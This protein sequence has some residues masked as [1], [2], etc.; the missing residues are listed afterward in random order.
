MKFYSL[1]KILEKKCQYNLVI[2]ERSNGKSYAAYEE[3][4][5]N[6]AESGDQGAIIRRYREDFKGKRGQSFFSPHVENGLVQ[7]YTGDEWTG[8]YYYSSQ[9][10][11]CRRDE[12]DPNK[13]I[14]S[15]E[16]FCYAFSLTDMEHDK[17]TSYPKVTT[18]VFD[19]FITR[20]GYLNDEFVLFMNV[21]STIIRYRNNVTIL[22][23]ANTVNK[24][25]PYFAEMGLNHVSEMTPGTIDVYQYGDSKLRVAV[26]Y[27]GQTKRQ[28]KPSDMY[29]SFDN[30]RL[31]M[32]TTGVWEIGLYPHKPVDFVPHDIKF[33]YFISYNRQLLQC[34]IVMTGKYN[35]TFVH[36]KTTEL[37]HPERDLIFDTEASPLYN[38][39]RKI[40][41]GMNKSKI[42]EKILS[43]YNNDKLFF[44]DNTTGEVMR[45]YLMWCKT[46]SFI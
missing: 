30:P 15:D 11:F 40:N 31:K 12:N 29:F 28:K 20:T 23:L 34:E 45:N 26:E 19:E 37:R 44:S 5:K 32:I 14:K 43:Y 2:G 24:D 39:S 38:R 22:M 36:P 33:T 8:I 7:K 17:S 27:C 35:F 16:P 10:F 18:I 25:C 21:L 42:V 13:L 6:Y 1:K 46:D 41:Q 9:W 3:I 4:I